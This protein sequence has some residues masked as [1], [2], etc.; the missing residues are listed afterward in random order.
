MKLN[1]HGRQKADRQ[2][3][4]QQPKPTNL[5]SEQL[6]WVTSGQDTL[7]TCTPDSSGF[8]GQEN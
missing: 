2:Y 3:S 8:S 1:V 5:Y 4:W 7:Q 6:H